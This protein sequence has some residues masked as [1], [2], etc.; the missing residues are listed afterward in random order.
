[1]AKE[2]NIKMNIHEEYWMYYEKYQKKYNSKSIV[3]MQ[4]GSF[5]EA[6]ST[7]T[8][9]PNLFELSELLNIV[10]TRKDKS[11]NIIDHK[12]PYMLGFPSVALSKFLKILID[13][14]YT[15]VII[16]QTT[17]PPNPLREVTGIYSPSTFIDNISV[18]NKYLMTFYIE[19]NSSLSSNKSNIS[20]GMCAVD[21][22]TGGVFYYESHSNGI[23]DGLEAIEEAQ[24]F[25]HYYRPIELIVYQIDNTNN[26]NQIENNKNNKIIDK[27]D[28]IPNQIIFSY[29]KINPNFTKISYQ[30]NLLSKVYK[31]NGIISPIELFN[32]AKNTCSIIAIVVSFDYIHQHN[33]NLIKELK[34]PV[35]FNEHKYMILANN[36]QYQLNIVDYYN[37]DI[38]NTKFQSLYSVLNNCCTAMGKR[39]LKN[40][41][42]APFTDY[43]VINNYYNLT[44]KIISSNKLDEI[45]SC[46]KG[47]SDLDKLFRKLS[48]KFIQ[49]YELYTIYD[50][51][52]NIISIINILK[53]SELKED[54]YKFFNKK[55]I[56]LFIESINYLENTF[57][58]DKLKIN[59]LIEIKDSFYK[60]D[61][62]TNI[63]NIQEKI[64]MSIGIIEKLA[65]HLEKFDDNLSLYIKHNDRDG[66]YL[67]TT[68]IRGHKLKKILDEKQINIINID[69]NISIKI[70][71]IKFNFQT[72]TAKISLN[73]IGGL[74]KYSDEIEELEKELSNLIKTTFYQDTI[75]WYNKYSNMFVLLINMIIEIDYVS[76]NAF[77]A[78]KYHYVKPNV[79]LN[80]DKSF[81]NASNL[82]HPIIER[83][84]DYEYVPHDVILDDDN[85]GNL[86]M[87]L[88][89][90]GKCFSPDT[91]LIMYDNSLKMAKDIQVNDL[92]M[93]DDSTPRKVL[94]TT[95]NT[96]LMYDIIPYNNN[97][98]NDLDYQ[99]KFTVN[100]PHILCLKNLDNIIIEISVDE[101][102]KKNNEWKQQFY[103]YKTIINYDDNKDKYVPMPPYIFGSNIFIKNLNKIPNN[104]KYN[105]INKRLQ[106]LA[107]IIDYNE[108]IIITNKFN[109]YFKHSSI[110]KDIIFL[111]KSI[112]FSCDV[113]NF[114]NIYYKIIIY[115][116]IELVNK[117]PLMIQR[118]NKRFLISQNNSL[119]LKFN[120]VKK[121]IS[122][123][124]GFETNGNKR[125][126]LDSFIVTHNSSLMK[127]VGTSLIMA[128]CGLY[129]PSDKFEYGVFDSLYTRISG[130]DNLFKGQSS[131]IIEMN[132]LRCILKKAN[133]KSLVI[134][135]E[136]C[137]GT[138]YISANAIVASAILKLVS[139]NTKF[140]FAT[141]L[142]DLIKIEKIKELTNIKFF[143]LSVEN[144][145]DELVF[146]RKM[147]EGCC[148]QLYGITIAKFILD[149]PLFI[150]TTLE[151]KNKLLEK[152]N[153]NT[154]LL[155]DKKSNYNNDLYM[156]SCSI[157]GSEDKLETH[158]INYQKDFIND[159][160]FKK[161][162]I[163][164]DSKA[165]LIILCDKCHDNL[166]SNK[167]KINTIQKS[168]NGIKVI[169]E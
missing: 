80:Y 86:I 4:V 78:L 40:R 93:G 90:C 156:D 132:E 123:Y 24:R 139:M 37:W 28:I 52:M 72:T 135:D 103:L 43:N 54:L 64:N 127:A 61:I 57:D 20:I 92:L 41:L 76:N 161:K 163:I 60:K 48:I 160:N 47:I 89:S 136:I 63:D 26:I 126:L 146:S 115:G 55:Y 155:N 143:H 151:I 44:E 46:L 138:E 77:T 14:S 147:I 167:F 113:E 5:H 109:I 118:K 17:P 31:N 49:P 25:Y 142:H 39:I 53:N 56:K 12:N 141:H 32:L 117:L 97:Y 99:N 27:I 116:N 30:N 22:S 140:L 164:K 122:T 7:D 94:G 65:K 66:Y 105:S 15:V 130:N 133:S 124:Y 42:C 84:I 70:S 152:S 148:E 111:I 119:L 83:I 67:T 16:D 112:G 51:F 108:V 50:S 149:D 145:G 59:N 87:G 23:T 45:R 18:E 102:L 79:N 21:S 71:D 58:I 34:T 8:R 129:V 62:H 128:Q 91:L 144:N 134:G 85:V 114:N 154:K 36:A 81:I 95:S 131:F 11:I 2:K 165:N 68:K 150:N 29:D 74:E 110:V 153:I 107:G 166:H 19:I 121:N 10:C 35:L 104:Y 13:N 158:H 120:I 162:H 96:G 157:C 9:G 101:Y 159:I 100:G 106:L 125:F 69:N 75:E 38:I 1:M 137:R 73:S 168:T 33:E 6:Y 3:L 169:F 98:Y 88:N 82:R